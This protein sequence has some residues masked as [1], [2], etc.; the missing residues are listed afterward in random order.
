M[1]ER[2]GRREDGEGVRTTGNEK[3]REEVDGQEAGMLLWN[4][5]NDSKLERF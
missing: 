3:E 4:G 5:R 1:K 2:K